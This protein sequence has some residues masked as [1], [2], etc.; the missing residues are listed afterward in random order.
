MPDLTKLRPLPRDLD[1]GRKLRTFAGVDE[2]VLATVPHERARY[3][4]VGGAVLGTATIATASF[5]LALAQIFDGWSIAL[6][7]PMLLWGLFVLN[8][9]RWLVSS[10]T[11]SKWTR[12]AWLLVPRLVLACF[13]G[14]IIAEPL[15]LGIFGKAI[16]QHVQEGRRAEIEA[17][18]K[19]LAGC[20]PTS[21]AAPTTGCTEADK[22][23][24]GTTPASLEQELANRREDAAALEATIRRDTEEHGKLEDLARRECAGVGGDGLTGVAGAGPECLRLRKQADDYAAAHPIAPNKAKLDD[25]TTRISDLEQNTGTAKADHDKAIA[26]EIRTR[27]QAKHDTYNGIGLLERFKALDELVAGN[28]FLLAALWAVRLFL[29]V[30]DCLPVLVKIF[31]GV[32]AYE[33][34]VETHLTS[35]VKSE[36]EELRVEEARRSSSWRI[37]LREIE[38]AE[39]KRMAEID[40]ELREHQV[41]TNRK[42]E[43]AVDELAALLLREAEE[44][45]VVNERLAA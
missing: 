20:N 8:L 16:E 14:V 44:K 5:G 40:L 37:Q 36:N 3:T 39:R 17:F 33:R 19:R 32:T 4:G 2:K 41:A 28:A 23:R 26:A 1:L 27:V 11:G 9:D 25:L 13:F 24:T 43:S 29:I 12:R 31:G 15:V 21:G 18:E 22:I 38:I 42:S 6:L 45:T 35:A 34:I 10:S 30:I 7:L